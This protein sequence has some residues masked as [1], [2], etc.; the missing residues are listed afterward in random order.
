LDKA[1]GT[2]PKAATAAVIRIGIAPYLANHNQL[3][4]WLMFQ[5]DHIPAKH[6]HFVATPLIRFFYKIY[7]FEI[8]YQ[9]DHHVMVNWTLQF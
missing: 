9:S 7:L 8:G 5:V 2:N 6:D 3:N 4:T 1:I